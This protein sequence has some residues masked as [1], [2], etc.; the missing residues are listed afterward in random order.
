MFGV[1]VQITYILQAT[2]RMNPMLD[3]GLVQELENE[4]FD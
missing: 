3:S 4:S 2:G 1:S